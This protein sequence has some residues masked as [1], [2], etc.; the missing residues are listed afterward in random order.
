MIR[1]PQEA[2]HEKICQRVFHAR[3]R[4]SKVDE[5]YW[6]AGAVRYWGHQSLSTVSTPPRW[7]GPIGLFLSGLKV[8]PR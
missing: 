7:Y 8:G 4:A 1:I 5:A 6:M 2:S 3:S